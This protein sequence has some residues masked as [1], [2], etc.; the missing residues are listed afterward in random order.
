MQ[1]KYV[2]V[3]NFRA[4][5]RPGSA[6]KKD[7]GFLPTIAPLG[8]SGSEFKWHFQVFSKWHIRHVFG[9]AE[10]SLPSFNDQANHSQS[11]S[12]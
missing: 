9:T 5:I 1:G 6:R 8:N 2:R 4:E 7:A 10:N 12:R 11:N 3:A